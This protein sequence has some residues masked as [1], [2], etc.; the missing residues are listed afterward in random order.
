MSNSQGQRREIISL[1]EFPRSS[2]PEPSPKRQRTSRS[3]S[4]NIVNIP[5]ET[6]SRVT[7]SPRNV[8]PAEPTRVIDSSERLSDPLED[9]SE[10]EVEPAEPTRV[11]DSS[12]RSSDQLGHQTATPGRDPEEAAIEDARITSS[13]ARVNDTSERSSQ[14]E[15]SPLM[16]ASWIL[17]EVTTSTG[18]WSNANDGFGASS[19]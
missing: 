10:E 11:M 16:A 17:P 1:P 19:L 15:D 5:R 7:R 12:E 4:K 3:T 2:T 6:R 13:L 14:S 9:R 8:E 18:S